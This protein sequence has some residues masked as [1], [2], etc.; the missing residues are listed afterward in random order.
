MNTIEEILRNKNIFEY[1][2]EKLCVSCNNRYND[3]DLCKIT[4][5]LDNTVKCDNYERCMTNK[6]KTCNKEE[7]CFNDEVCKNKR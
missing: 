7:E 6:C 4:K 5:R 3:R 2:A 1:Y